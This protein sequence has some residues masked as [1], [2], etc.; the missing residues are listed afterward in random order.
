MVSSIVFLTL[1]VNA[2]LDDAPRVSGLEF[3]DGPAQGGNYLLIG[4][5]T[6]AFVENATQAE[7]F[8]SADQDGVGGQRGDVM[9]VLHI[10]PVTR[11]SLLVSFPRDLLV[12]IPGKGVGQINDAFNDGPQAVIDL[13]KADFDLA[14]NHYVEVNF[15]AFIGVVNAVGS[16]NVYFP[17]PSRDVNSGLDII[18]A[19]CTPLDG[20]GS[21]AYVRSRYL[22]EL[23]DGQWRDASPRADID[24]IGRQQ[25]FIRK[26]ASQASAKAGQNPLD[27][28]EI[29]NAIV[30]K[31]TLDDQLSNGDILRLV[32][33]F[34]N[35]DPTQPGAL[36][37][38]TLPWEQS[39]SQA[40][41]LVAKQ[42][43]ADQLI[44][45]LRSFGDST[46]TS[47]QT[48]RPA[49][50]TVQVLN[51]TERN[52]EAGKSLAK[53]QEAG[54][55]PASPADA[56]P[57]PV[58]LI[59]YAPGASAKA[60]LVGRYL[61]GV[62]QLIEDP[63]LTDVDVAVVIGE[64]WRGIRAKDQVPKAAPTTTSTTTAAKKGQT[65]DSGVPTC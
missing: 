4:S 24:R 29:A 59:R 30:P 55:A 46:A 50:V 49:D 8:G 38:V 27:A 51:G 3:P 52:G 17:Y 21:L 16:I 43:E 26:L 62:G 14:I 57:T 19:G 10:D 12:Q 41:R 34:R 13:L 2:T 60:E 53:L 18:S 36:E 56:D 1:K 25:D 45:R 7:A 11:T 64:D 40:G 6:R 15:E 37:M 9:M 58:T 23:R 63:S 5:D 42:P 35:V 28:I 47:E 48:V 39:T 20:N 61:G 54:F 33:T 44:A 65:P 31:L 22:E 32:K